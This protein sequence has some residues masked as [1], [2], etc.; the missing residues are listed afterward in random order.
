MYKCVYCISYYIWV[1]RA[2]PCAHLCG[3]PTAHGGKTRGGTSLQWAAFLFSRLS[4]VS[5]CTR[6][7]KSDALP[8]VR[9]APFGRQAS[10]ACLA[11][12]L[13]VRPGGWKIAAAETAALEE[14]S[15][16]SHAAPASR[17]VGRR[18]SR[19]QRRRGLLFKGS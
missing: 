11:W 18:P 13:E 1:R 6:S 8:L 15:I 9:A 4:W 17:G 3:A 14:N 19:R 2:P 16:I 12:R 7:P 10:R 5:A